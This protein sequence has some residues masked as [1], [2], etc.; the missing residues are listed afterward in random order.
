[1]VVEG[2]VISNIQEPVASIVEAFFLSRTDRDLYSF[3]QEVLRKPVVEK[4][5]EKTDGNRYEATRIL[6]SLCSEVI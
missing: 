1:M 5:A 6:E 3:L 4:M 2:R